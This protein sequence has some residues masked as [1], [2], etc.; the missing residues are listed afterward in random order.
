MTKFI[1]LNLCCIIYE[2]ATNSFFPVKWSMADP[3]VIPTRFFTRPDH[4]SRNRG[5][6]PHETITLVRECKAVAVLQHSYFLI[7]SL[8]KSRDD[9]ITFNGLPVCLQTSTRQCTQTMH[10]CT[11]QKRYVS[12][13]TS[14]YHVLCGMVL[15]FQICTAK[16]KVGSLST[17]INGRHFRISFGQENCL[18]E[19]QFTLSKRDKLQALIFILWYK[20]AVLYKHA[21]RSAQN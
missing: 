1:Y 4:R 7:F 13:P 2:C 14:D 18:V 11:V 16:P 5:T 21:L 10:E 17:E 20:T 19:R 6:D 3:N 15:S 8:H 9:C 12:D